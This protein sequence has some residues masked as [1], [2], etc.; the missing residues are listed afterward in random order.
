[1]D[2]KRVVLIVTSTLAQN[3]RASKEVKALI[4]N[5]HMVTFLG[6]NRGVKAPTVEAVESTEQLTEIQL[7]LKAPLGTKIVLFYPFWWCFVFFRLILGKWDIAHA[8][9]LDSIPP[10]V[11]AGK[12]KRKP[13]I[14]EI[15]DGYE[16]SLLLPKLIRDACVKVDKLFMRLANAIVIVDEMQIE[17]FN[18]I[19]NSKVVVAYDSPADVS[20]D[21]SIAHQRNSTF[22][23]F[24]GGILSSGRALNLDKFFAAIKSI[25][26]IRVVIAGWGDLVEEIKGW[27]R[28][29]PDTIKFIGAISHA[30]VLQRTTEADLLFMLRSP[31][32]LVNK[33]I[34]GSKLLEAM[35]FGKPILVNKGTSTARKVS[36]E[37]CGLVT[38]ANNIEEIGEAIIKLRDNPAL[39]EEL[40]ANA[41]K[42]YEQKYGWH[43]MERRLLNLYDELTGKV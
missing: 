5:G 3:T 13:T 15:V 2:G 35:V 16:D 11:I 1:M 29:M 7:R 4:E 34:C 8:I 6:W 9:N 38:D 19:P 20:A 36:E 10:T 42:A 32:P 17:A 26:D 12:L 21:I 33:Y 30:E 27:S 39:C 18:G 24:Y 41:R 25:E 14:Y 37:N 31:T 23:L 40:G 28:Q 22:T 43:I